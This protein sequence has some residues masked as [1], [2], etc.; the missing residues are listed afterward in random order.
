MRLNPEYFLF[1]VIKYSLFGKA[2][3]YDRVLSMNKDKHPFSILGPDYGR[4][5]C[6]Y[7]QYFL[8]V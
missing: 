7:M 5:D 1:K 2:H 4:K 6:N 8:Q 3:F